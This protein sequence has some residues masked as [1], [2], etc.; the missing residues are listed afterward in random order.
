MDTTQAYRDIIETLNGTE[1]QGAWVRTAKCC[2]VRELFDLPKSEK[3][4]A[5]TMREV[6]DEGWS[7]LIYFGQ[8]SGH[9][10][11][12]DALK[13]FGWKSMG[14]FKSNQTGLVLEGIFFTRQ[15]DTK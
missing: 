7:A 2:G 5:L 14:K 15:R 6:L 10:L 12:L 3:G 1:R 9:A 8:V 13:K 4:I 11:E